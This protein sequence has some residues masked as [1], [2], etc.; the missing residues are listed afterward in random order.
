MLRVLDLPAGIE[1]VGPG[2]AETDDPHR[3]AGPA[4]R[5]PAVRHVRTRTADILRRRRFEHP[6]WRQW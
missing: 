6:G 2:R 1:E 4:I 5:P 3:M